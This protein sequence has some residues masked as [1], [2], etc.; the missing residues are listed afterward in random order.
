MILNAMRAINPEGQ[1]DAM[2]WHPIFEF[3]RLTKKEMMKKKNS[4]EEVVHSSE[5][6]CVHHTITDN[7]NDF[8]HQKVLK[9]TFNMLHTFFNV[10]IIG[11]I[12]SLPNNSW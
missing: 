9:L 2:E 8:I 1:E 10:F 3:R 6:L 11:F 5:N 4:S 12:Q 7:T